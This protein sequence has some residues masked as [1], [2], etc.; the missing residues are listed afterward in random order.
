MVDVVQ[1]LR[2][3]AAEIPILAMPNAGLPVLERGRTV[4]KETPAQMADSAGRLVEAGANII[5]GCCG[6]GP[7]HIQAMKQ[8]VLGR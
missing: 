3:T 8:A 1:A 7:D 5:G 2:S 6:T 4:F